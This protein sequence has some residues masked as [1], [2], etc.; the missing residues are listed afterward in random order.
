MLQLWWEIPPKL[1]FAR[2]ESKTVKQKGKGPKEDDECLPGMRANAIPKKKTP[3]QTVG[4]T[5]GDMTKEAL[6]RSTAQITR[7][8]QGTGSARKGYLAS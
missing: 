2:A 6:T 4:K 5:E 7:G 3:P 8:I 1:G